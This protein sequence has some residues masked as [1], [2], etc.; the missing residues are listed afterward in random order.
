MLEELSANGARS[1]NVPA[2]SR[3]LEQLVYEAK[4]AFEQYRRGRCFAI[5]LQRASW[6]GDGNEKLEEIEAKRSSNGFF[7]SGCT[8]LFVINLRRG[9]QN[10]LDG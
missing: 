9:N 3:K 7:Q 8:A 6:N 5:G 2:L 4:K 1:L 10:T